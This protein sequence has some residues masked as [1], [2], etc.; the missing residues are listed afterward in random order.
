MA[1]VMVGLSRRASKKPLTS[2]ARRQVAPAHSVAWTRPERSRAVPPMGDGGCGVGRSG[3]QWGPVGERPRDCDPCSTASTSTPST[4]RAA[5]RC[6]PGFATRSPRVSCSQRGSTRTSTSIRR[7]RGSRW[8]SHVSPSSIRSRLK[9][10][11]SSASCSPVL[12]RTRRTSKDGCSCPRRWPTMRGCGKEVVVAG[13]DDHLEI[14]NRA[15]WSEQLRE[16]EGSVHDVAE[17]LAEKR[18]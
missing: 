18:S 4:T 6:R 3:L 16:V 12:P 5:S 2:S 17:R 9:P 11:G 13:V 14:W 8:C 15:A 7:L 1:P 10:A